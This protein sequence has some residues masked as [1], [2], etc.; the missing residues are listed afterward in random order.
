[1]SHSTGC[2]KASAEV[3]EGEITD[4]LAASDQQ[5]SLDNFGNSI[6]NKIASFGEAVERGT[7]SVEEEDMDTNT[8]DRGQGEIDGEPPKKRLKIEK[9]GELSK[10]LAKARKGTGKKM[11]VEIYRPPKRSVRIDNCNERPPKVKEENENRP[12]IRIIHVDDYDLDRNVKIKIKNDHKLHPAGVTYKSE[13][14][15]A[16]KSSVQYHGKIVGSTREGCVY[17]L[18]TDNKAV[19]KDI[20][21]HFSNIVGQHKK[22]PYGTELKFQL[23][24]SP[25][26]PEAKHAEVVGKIPGRERFDLTSF[27]QILSI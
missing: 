3:E 26:G 8:F 2:D 6:V 27:P 23:E 18:R 10:E 9:A 1:M 13:G 25:K 11:A 17:F 20:Y 5:S 16:V 19:T 15:L 4:E 12:A 14:G 24:S 7:I 22:L 21:L